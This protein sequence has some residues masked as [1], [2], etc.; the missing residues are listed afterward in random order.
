MRGAA[1]AERRARGRGLPLVHARRL[2]RPAAGQGKRRAS[3]AKRIQD[4]PLPHARPPHGSASAPV[5]LT[6]LGHAAIELRER[7]GARRARPRAAPPPPRARPRKLSCPVSKAA[8]AALELIARRRQQPVAVEGEHAARLRDPLLGTS[9]PPRRT[10]SSRPSRSLR[11]RSELA[12]APPRAPRDAGRAGAARSARRPT[13][14]PELRTPPRSR[15]SPRSARSRAGTRGARAPTAASPAR[16]RASAARSSGR[17]AS[18]ASRSRARSGVA[19]RARRGRGRRREREPP[20][21]G[22]ASALSCARDHAS[23]S[24]GRPCSRSS[25]ASSNSARSGACAETSPDS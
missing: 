12:R 8:R 25:S 19:G 18:A 1:G 2:R 7:A 4:R 14:G 11:A 15:R 22:G 23:R 9:R 10:S 21:A 24:R 17:S 13:N 6:E 20:G 3:A 16:T 5:A